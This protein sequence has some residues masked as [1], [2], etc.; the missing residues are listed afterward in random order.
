MS[1]LTS[2]HKGRVAEDIVTQH[3][4]T[5]GA[6]LL[7]RRWRGPGGEIDLIFAQNDYIVFVEVK[8][9]RDPTRAVQNLRARQIARLLQSAEDCLGHFPAQSR[10]LMRFDVALVDAMGQV[11][12][13]EN[14]L[15]A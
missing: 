1:G 11:D 12:I 7:C 5:Q 9:S 15:A 3:Y 10:T 8:A 4:I 2:Y 6:R 13:I 14:A